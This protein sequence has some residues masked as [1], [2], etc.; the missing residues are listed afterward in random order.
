MNTDHLNLDKL[1]DLAPFVFVIIT[2]LLIGVGIA[3]YFSSQHIK[4]LKE[5]IS[6]LKGK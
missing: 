2:I 3:G 5:F 4:T 6:H 1:I